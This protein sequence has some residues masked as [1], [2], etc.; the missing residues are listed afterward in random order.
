MDTFFMFGFLILLLACVYL[1]IERHNLGVKHKHLQAQKDRELFELSI[2]SEV[3]DKI[4][5]SLSSKDIASTIALTAGKLFPVSSV[6]YAVIDS[7]HIEFNTMVHEK[8]EDVYMQSIKSLVFNGMYAIDSTLKQY[9]LVEKVGTLTATSQQPQVVQSASTAPLSYFNIPLVLNNRFTGIINVS[10]KYAQAFNETDMSMLYKI[11]NRAQLA[12]G[13]L[14]EVIESE[15]DK[16]ESMVKSLSSGA[17]LL[18]LE[19]E[20]M[21]IYTINN[22]AKRFL[23]I[24]SDSP[25]IDEVLARFEVKPHIIPE[26]KDV[27]EKKKSTIYRSVVIGDSKYN[28]YITPVF[29]RSKDTIIGVSLTMQDITRE[30]EIEKIRESFTNMMVHELRTPLSAIRGAVNLL[31]TTD[32]P[33]M[34]QTRMR[35]VI[36]NSTERLL[37]D[38]NDILDSA[39]IDAGK[40]AIVKSPSDI[41]D[42]IQKATE[43]VSYI[44]KTRAIL[45]EN[46][47][48]EGLPICDFDTQRIGQVVLNM[49]SNS[50]KFSNEGGVIKVFSR[51]KDDLLEVEVA[52]EGS[53]IPA[54]RKS[55]LFKPFA[56]A[57]FSKSSKG[58]GLGL[59]ISKV[60]IERHGGKIWLESEEGHGTRAFFTLPIKTIETEIQPQKPL[61]K[62]PHF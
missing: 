3:S 14:E 9:P 8:L 4:G 43:E 36:K 2:I 12:I 32:L 33:E 19:G 18:T 50:I 35:L 22:A 6:S 31:L 28:I 49:L 7:D 13:R 40:L 58:T 17:I 61:V 11:V 54:D 46:H 20:S 47:L 29:S 25:G 53:G 30:N 26:L 15:K 56:Q 59:Y 21:K 44:A 38:V 52:D 60:I 1:F 62:N 10:S 5:Y 41:N 42:V 45:I 39:K 51:I 34:E 16:V 57:N 48:S 24:K 37:S 27:I 23:D 55:S